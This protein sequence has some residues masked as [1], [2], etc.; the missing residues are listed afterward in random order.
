MNNVKENKMN[1]RDALKSMAAT[2]IGM[3]TPNT[4][5]ADEPKHLVS[6]GLIERSGVCLPVGWSVKADQYDN[7]VHF[8]SFT[9]SPKHLILPKQLNYYWKDHFGDAIEKGHAYHFQIKSPK[10]NLNCDGIDA[11]YRCIWVEGVDGG[12]IHMKFAL[13]FIDQF[14]HE[15]TIDGCYSIKIRDTPAGIESVIQRFE[16]DL[17]SDKITYLS[18]SHDKDY[19]IIKWK[20]GTC[21]AGIWNPRHTVR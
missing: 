16:N 13:T 12:K 15:Q 10:G 11:G 4:L 20:E 3:L 17:N 1:R 18:V 19:Y 2:G 5:L 6:W 7:N 14:P 21:G 8:L 9:F